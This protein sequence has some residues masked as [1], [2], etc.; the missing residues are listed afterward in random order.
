M[1][2]KWLITACVIIGL[3]SSSSCNE[4]VHKQEAR[5]LPFYS[6]ADFT[7]AWI[8]PSNADYNKIHSIPSFSFIDQFGDTVT[9]RTFDNKIY[10]ANFFFTACPAICKQLTKGMGLVQQAFKTNHQVRLISHSV[11]PDRDNVGVLLNYAEQH[12]VIKGKWH[13]VTGNRKEIYTIARQSYFAEEDMGL[14]QSQDDFLHT[15]NILLIDKKR[16]IR[17]VY[18]GTDPAEIN[19]LIADIK[20]LEKES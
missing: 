10:V 11:T 15:E 16:R 3:L 13:L 2:Y 12:K 9:E 20:V 4:A 6:S 8:E 18:K 14:Q 1:Q 19:N 5:Q 17:G 7:P